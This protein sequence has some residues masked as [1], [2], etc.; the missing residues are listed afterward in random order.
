MITLAKLIGP[1]SL[2][3]AEFDRLADERVL[4]T[5]HPILARAAEAPGGVSALAREIGVGR[6]VLRKFL[7]EHS[8]PTPS[9]LQ[10]M[11]EWALDRPAAYA[12]FGSV[13][14]RT[15]TSELPPE[16][17]GSARAE[18]AEALALTYQ[19]AGAIPNWLR[20]EIGMEA[21]PPVRRRRARARSLFGEERGEE[22]DDVDDLDDE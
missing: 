18:V 3:S 15:L 7:N 22:D 4:E 21:K 10:K 5:L 13:L 11:R 16:L 20:S 9:N 8:R 2:E 14:L 19:R 12:P 1:G 6:I 17:R